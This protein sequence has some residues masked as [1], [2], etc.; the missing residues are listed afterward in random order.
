MDNNEFIYLLVAMICAALLSFTATPIARVIACKVGAIDV[1]KDG[2]RMHK[3][4]IP[5]MGGLA[6]SFSF[7]V[8][9]MVFCDIH[10]SPSTLST[11]IALWFGGLIIVL[12]GVLDDVF[13]LNAWIKLA[14]QIAAAVVCISQGLTIKFISLFGNYIVLG[15]LEIPLTLLWIVGLTNAINLIDGLDGLSCGVSAICSL[16]L[17]LVTIILTDNPSSILMTGILAGSCIGFLPFNTNPAKIF[18]GDT[19]ALFLGYVL[20]VLSIDGLFK[21]H[22]AMSFLIPLSIFGLPLFDTGFAFLRRI[23]H[24][25]SPFSPDRGHIHHRLIDMGFNQKQSVAI[26]YAICGILGISA[27]MLTGEKWLQAGIIIICGVVIF[28]VDYVIVKNPRTRAKAGL[29]LPEIISSEVKIYEAETREIPVIKSTTQMN[30]E[31]GANE[32]LEEDV[33][34]SSTDASDFPLSSHSAMSREEPSVSASDLQTDPEHPD[35]QTTSE[36]KN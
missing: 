4:P 2:R 25:K 11:L 17:L 30:S 27:V 14:G 12:V 21:F 10:A 18:I 13:R 6:V 23:L 34:V 35:P 31:E 28:L 20:A 29:D 33:P 36:K 24:G 32:I 22:T 1:P 19:G 26:L 16:S 3:K 9:T 15:K 5:R 8:A 7:I